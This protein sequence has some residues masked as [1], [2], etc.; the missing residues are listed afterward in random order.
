MK[1]TLDVGPFGNCMCQPDRHD[2][3][4]TDQCIA[5]PFG[6]SGHGYGAKVSDLGYP[7]QFICR[8]FHGPEPTAKH[9]VAH[10]CGNR[11]CINPKHLRWATHTENEADKLLHGTH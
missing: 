6:E 11:I 2:P 3:K 1:G 9:E 4:E 10:G 5:W 7:H 8:K